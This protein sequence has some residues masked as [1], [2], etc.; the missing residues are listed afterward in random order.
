MGKIKEITK[1]MGIYEWFLLVKILLLDI[2]WLIYL[3]IVL[4]VN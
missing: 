1:Y 3:L 2:P 4:I